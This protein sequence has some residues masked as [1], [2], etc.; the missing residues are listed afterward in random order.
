MN[1]DSHNLFGMI[2]HAARAHDASD[3]HLIAGLPPAFRVSGEIITASDCDPLSREALLDLA[4]ALLTPLQRDRLEQER[5]LSISYFHPECGRIRLSLYHRIGVPEMAIRMC[6]LE[7]RTAEEL[8]LPPVIERLTALTSGLVIVTGPTG[9][10][11]TTTLNYMVDAINRT[12]RGKIITIEDPVEFEHLHRKCLVTQIEVGTD[13]L[14]FARCLRHVLRLNPDVICVGEMRDLDTMETALT[15]AETGHLVIATLHTP[16]AVST[17]ERIAF[18]F[19]G[20]RQAQV[21]FQLAT[22]LQAVVAQRLIPRLDRQGRVLATEVLVAN[23]AVRNIVREKR[24]HQLYNVVSTAKAEDGMH[25]L[26]SSL[27]DLYQRG[28]I[29]Y[30]AA[31]AQAPDAERLRSLIHSRNGSVP[32]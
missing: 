14:S 17:V 3:I 29:A 2:L 31:L 27:V 8:M 30:D 12:R 21:V 19:D 9:M 20:P 23:D 25:T 24:L 6:N 16:N 28:L 18:A 7:V 1:D 22:T 10:G 4:N 15:A 32:L 26:E 11:K 5:E 13:T